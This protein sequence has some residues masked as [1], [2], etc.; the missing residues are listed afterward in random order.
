[1]TAN[2]RV[3]I[4]GWLGGDEDESRRLKRRR[5]TG[6]PGNLAGSRLQARHRKKSR[7][8]G[9]GRIIKRMRNDGIMMMEND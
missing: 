6:W 8:N 1:M 9:S 3:C 5:N 4:L 2:K 7:R